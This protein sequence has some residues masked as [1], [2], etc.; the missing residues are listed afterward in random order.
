MNSTFV[1]RKLAAITIHFHKCGNL[2]VVLRQVWVRGSIRKEEEMR[3]GGILDLGITLANGG[4]GSRF[5][6]PSHFP[7]IHAR[8][9]PSQVSTLHFADFST[10]KHKCG[11]VY[12]LFFRG[13]LFAHSATLSYLA[14]ASFPPPPM[15]WGRNEIFPAMKMEN[16]TGHPFFPLSPKGIFGL[17]FFPRFPGFFFLCLP[18]R[19]SANMGTRVWRRNGEN[20]VRTGLPG[21]EGPPAPSSSKQYHS[22]KKMTRCWSCNC[23]FFP[24]HHIFLENKL[25]LN[26]GFALL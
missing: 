19:S 13:L 8:I 16:G 4:Q 26:L 22:R 11:R 20:P 23:S 15:F 14:C 21:D 1:L 2:V 10:Q 7:Y 18:H 25:L 3:G 12:F 6:T 5:A 17:F 24:R 9:R